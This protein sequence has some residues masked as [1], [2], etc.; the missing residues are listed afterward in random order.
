VN[1]GLGNDHCIATTDGVG[2]DTAIGGP[3]TDTGFT[4]PGDARR[5]LEREEPCFAE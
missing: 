4:D 3:G 5:G 2:N 1:G